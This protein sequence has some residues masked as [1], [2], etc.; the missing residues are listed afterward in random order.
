MSEAIDDELKKEFEKEVQAVLS[1]DDIERAKLLIG[2]KTA[3]SNNRGK[4]GYVRKATEDAI[5]NYSWGVGDD[6]P[7]HCDPDYAENTR[8]GGIIAPGTMLQV[9]TTT[10]RGDPIPDDIKKR[11]RSLFS[12]IHV[13]V[14]GSDKYFYNPIREGDGAYGYGGADDVVVKPSEFA[15]RSVTR[16]SSNVRMRAG[17]DIL[18]ISRSRAIHTERK[19]AVKKGK[20]ADIK[21]AYYTDEDLARIDAI[22]AQE[23]P[24]GAEP[25]YWEDVEVGESLGDAVKGPLTLSEIIVFH[26]GGY[27]L[28]DYGV[29]AS[30]MGYKVRSKIPA[31]FIK[32]ERGVPDVSQRVHWDSKWAQAIGNPMAYDYSVMREGWFNHYLNDWVGDDG[33][34][35]RQY[36][37]VRKFNYVGDTQFIYGEV[38]AKREEGGRFYVDAIIKMTNQR[39]TVTAV[40]EA[41]LMLPSREHGPVILPEPPAETVAEAKAMWDRHLELT[42]E[43]K[44]KKAANK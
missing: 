34:V 11:T 1:D 35:F 26:A 16:F 20:Y 27:G 3:S 40:G 28:T 33:W 30:R 8:W 39:D 25:R 12:G 5:R 17:G 24:R 18:S 7:L 23:K 29:H 4:G 9:M 6:N 21:P 41:T 14:A 15:G 44:A 37:E 19:A 22:Y 38:T 31:F 13:F 2:Y 32:D 43:A 10:M 42:A 36:D